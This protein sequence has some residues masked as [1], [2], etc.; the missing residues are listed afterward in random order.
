MWSASVT[1][2][3]S[4]C[5]QVTGS[6]PVAA[7]SGQHPLPGKGFLLIFFE[8]VSGFYLGLSLLYFSSARVC[9]FLFPSFGTSL[10]AKCILTLTSRPSLPDTYTPFWYFHSLSG[11]VVCVCYQLWWSHSIHHSHQ[12]SGSLPLFDVAPH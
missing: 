1:T 3:S 11:E 8:V 2:V 9:L 5:G 12:R 10:A 7:G 6:S 4:F